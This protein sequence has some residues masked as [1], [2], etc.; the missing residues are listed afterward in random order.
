M[1]QVNAPFRQFSDIDGDPLENGQIYIG[2]AGLSAESNQVAITDDAGNTLVQPVRTLGGRAVNGNTPVNINVV[3]E[4]YSITVRNKN[5]SLVASALDVLSLTGEVASSVSKLTDFTFTSTTSMAAGTTVGGVSVTPILGTGLRTLG[6]HS[7]NDGG[8]S[9]YIVTEDAQNGIDKIDLGDGLTATL[10]H[11]QSEYLDLAKLGAE[12]DD[13]LQPLIV[14]AVAS[15]YKKFIV[16]GSY[17]CSSMTFDDL[18]IVL[19]AATINAPASE[20]EMFLNCDNLRLEAR[21]F[22]T[23]GSTTPYTDRVY[24][25]TTAATLDKLHVCGQL[26]VDCGT[27]ADSGFAADE[28]VTHSGSGMAISISDIEIK[29]FELSGIDFRVDAMDDDSWVNINNIKSHSGKG[30]CIQFGDNTY[31]VNQV[32]ITD[33][34]RLGDVASSG[35][36]EAKGAIVYGRNINISGNVVENVENGSTSGGEGIYTKGV[37]VSITNNKL[38]NAGSSSDGCIT[39]KGSS[40]WD[41]EFSDEGGYCVIANNIV[42][43]TDTDHDSKGIGIFDSNVVCIG[44]ILRDFRSGRSSLSYS[45]AISIGGSEPVSNVTVANNVVNG[46]Y[47][48]CGNFAD[49]SK[50]RSRFGDNI[51]VKNN[52]VLGLDGGAF[53]VFDARCILEDRP[54]TLDSASKTFT[55]DGGSSQNAEFSRS[56]FTV[57]KTIEVSDTSS[58]NGT[59]TI[60]A[61][62]RYVLTVEEAVTN[63]SVSP[64]IVRT[65]IDSLQITGNSVEGFGT[66]IRNSGG[67]VNRMLI[68][69]NDWSNG[70]FVYRLAIASGINELHIGAGETYTDV[71]DIDFGTPVATTFYRGMKV[72]TATGGSMVVTSYDDDYTIAYT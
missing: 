15:G 54:M 72:K 20:A 27:T 22:S 48:F 17:E 59:F 10:Q 56:I 61:V 66:A 43:L 53:V 14:A 51:K 50:G 34:K 57:G 25:F 33:C 68:D 47:N 52:T 26:L 1:P 40:Y 9:N 11:P 32:S 7:A 45:E 23:I 12:T 2:T 69:D 70:S 6:F 65:S 24:S 49:S 13:D 67:T 60:A 3:S 39:L 30:R 38:T 8:G 28:G 21:G 63:E 44:N 5:G 41:D 58:N 29:S 55:I 16:K 71:G 19:D 31:G 35:S 36:S 4:R 46:W 62:D 37:F 42:E 18:D 64:T